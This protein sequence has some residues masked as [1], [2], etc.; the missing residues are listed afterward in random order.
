VSVWIVGIAVGVLRRYL[1]AVASDQPSAGEAPEGEAAPPAARGAG[2]Q[3]TLQ[4]V[5]REIGDLPH[6]LQLA[7]VLCD[8]EE[9]R[10]ADVARMLGI[11]RK[12][13]WARVHEARGRLGGALDP[14]VELAQVVR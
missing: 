12:A 6:D 13:L 11:P 1:A 8:L 9:I 10:G 14:V 7:F 5:A 4:R 3:S 2:H